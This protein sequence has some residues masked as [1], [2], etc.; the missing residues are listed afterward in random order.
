MSLWVSR[1]RV[2]TSS[3]AINQRKEEEKTDVRACSGEK[4]WLGSALQWE[5]HEEKVRAVRRAWVGTG[6]CSCNGHFA[7][8]APLVSR[9]C[10]SA[11]GHGAVLITLHLST[12]HHH[13][14]RRRRPDRTSSSSS[15]FLSSCA[16]I[17]PKKL[18]ASILFTFSQ[19]L[20][21]LPSHPIHWLLLFNLWFG[22]DCDCERGG[23]WGRRGGQPRRR[24]SSRSRRPTTTTTTPA[25]GAS[26]PMCVSF[27]EISPP[28]LVMD[29][30]IDQ[31]FI[32]Y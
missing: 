7:R 19:L 30:S 27:N 1:I 21:F 25:S 10:R 32:C 22:C 2:S 13:L 24:P 18:A 16:S 26:S 14:D 9:S 12:D 28:S 15:S 23:W 17:H 20:L 11:H 4:R 5:F 3:G 29:R 6:H 8:L 31:S